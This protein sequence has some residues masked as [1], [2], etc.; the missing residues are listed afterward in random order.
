M[1]IGPEQVANELSGLSKIIYSTGVVDQE[2]RST[3][4]YDKLPVKNWNPSGSGWVGDAHFERSSSF[5]FSNPTEPIAEEYTEISQQFTITSKQMDGNSAFTKDFLVKLVGGV[6]SFGD[7]TYK[8]DDLRLSMQKNLNQGCYIGPTMLRATIPANAGPVNTFAISNTQYLFQ[9][10]YID[11]YDAG[12]VLQIPNRKITLISG[13]NITIDGAAVNVVAGWQIFHRMENLNSGSGKGIVSLPQICDDTTAFAATFENISR[14]TFPGWRGIVQDEAGNPL[15]N[16]ILQEAAN[17]ILTTSGI[18]YMTGN[19]LNF[20]HPDMIRR[21]L[22]IVL[23]LKRYIN[24]SK[25]DTGMEKPNMLEFNGKGIVVDP[26][27]GRRDWYMIN[28]DHVGKM[29]LFPLGVESQFGGS[30]MKWK[31]GYMQGISL[32][33]F[34]GQVGSDRNNCNCVIK[35]L[36]AI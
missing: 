7:Y 29:E 13:N 22:P 8:L 11:I 30:A 1:A 20:V 2:Q 16:D 27:C 34:S 35:N 4:T 21:M 3:V 5:K 19:Y 18:D 23:T 26:D 31:S 33:Y 6:T 36:Q 10:E 32:F 24:A 25:Y 14:N 15:T 9:G 28:T 12:G 17:S